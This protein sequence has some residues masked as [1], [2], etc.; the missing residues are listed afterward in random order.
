M[1]DF[2]IGLAVGALGAYVAVKLSDEETRNKIREE[3]DYGLAV[4][5]RKFSRAQEYANQELEKGR[6]SL[7]RVTSTVREKASEGLVD[8]GNKIKP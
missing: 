6:D 1:K 7:D 2:L 5:R 4:G 3:V 8:L